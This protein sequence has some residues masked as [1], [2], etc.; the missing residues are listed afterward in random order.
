MGVELTR[1]ERI[2]SA[3]VLARWIELVRSGSSRFAWTESAR[4]RRADSTRRVSPMGVELARLV[5]SSSW[6]SYRCRPF[7]GN[8]SATVRFE[9]YHM[10]CMRA[11]LPFPKSCNSTLSHTFIFVYV[12]IKFLCMRTHHPRDESRRT[13]ARGTAQGAEPMDDASSDEDGV[14][15][16]LR[17]PVCNVQFHCSRTLGRHRAP[18]VVCW[19]ASDDEERPVAREH[20]AERVAPRAAASSSV[21]LAP[22]AHE[23]RS[24]CSSSS[25]SSQLGGRD[26]A[27]RGDGGAIAGGSGR[28]RS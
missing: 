8:R 1:S 27:R 26:D 6:Q 24:N 7:H 17:C 9:L 12:I 21:P 4:P 25:A 18:C 15:G 13:A 14:T 11:S 23:A 20:P 5:R 28:R 16:S 10:D 2:G 22:A 3:F 19:P